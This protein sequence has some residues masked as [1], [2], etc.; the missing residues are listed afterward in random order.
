MYLKEWSHQGWKGWRC[1]G[2]PCSAGPWT[3]HGSWLHVAGRMGHS[4]L[5]LSAGT[6]PAQVLPQLHLLTS[7]SR[8]APV[9]IPAYSGEGNTLPSGRH[10]RCGTA[11]SCTHLQGLLLLLWKLKT[12]LLTVQ[13]V[14]MSSLVGLVATTGPGALSAELPKNFLR[15]LLLKAFLVSAEIDAHMVPL[16]S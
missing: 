11:P 6:S 15:V 3:S 14:Q 5:P 7:A 13:V 1:C 9:Q 10:S 12:S 8:R 4:Y 16:F 2:Q